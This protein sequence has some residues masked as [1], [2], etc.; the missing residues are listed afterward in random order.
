M[1][2]KTNSPAGSL[3]DW[4]T[5]EIDIRVAR[6]VLVALGAAAL[7]LLGVAID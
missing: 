6:W 3:K 1:D 2:E 7:I 5:T 4:L